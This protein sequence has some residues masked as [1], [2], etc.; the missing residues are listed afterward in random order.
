MSQNAYI[1]IQFKGDG[2]SP[3]KLKALTKFP[4][5]ILVESGEVGTKGKYR[6]VPSPYGIA[7][8]KIAPN[9]KA[10]L[11]WCDK[12]LD[13]KKSLQKS[14]VG[15]IIFDIESTSSFSPN[16]S[17]TPELS[18]RLSKLGAKI[19]FSEIPDVELDE[20]VEQLVVH[21]KNASIPKKKKDELLR[22]LLAFKTVGGNEKISA[23]VA[24]A[25]MVAF[26]ELSA[27][28]SLTNLYFSRYKEEFQE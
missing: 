6:G 17:V 2:F 15:E 8:L 4:L 18:S 19:V 10:I 9:E 13:Q 3:V 1:D 28:K 22:N 7:L 5:E 14:K 16:F 24:Y 26:I 27:G 11:E 25:M 20:F 23:R 12:L 21:F